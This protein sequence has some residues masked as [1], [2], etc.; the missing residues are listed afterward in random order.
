VLLTE[1]PEKT[2]VHFDSSSNIDL[3]DFD[4]RLK[5]SDINDLGNINSGP[6][7]PIMKLDI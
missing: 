5:I 4:S 1:I 3:I 6:S 7:R 2:T